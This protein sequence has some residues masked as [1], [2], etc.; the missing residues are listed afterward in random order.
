[1][2]EHRVRKCNILGKCM[3]KDERNKKRIGIARAGAKL[4]SRK[5]LPRRYG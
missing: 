5:V 4:F 1:M 3:M 2:W